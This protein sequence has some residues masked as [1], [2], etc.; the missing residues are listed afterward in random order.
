MKFRLL[1]EKTK[2]EI[3]ILGREHPNSYDYWDGNWV[4]S[5]VKVQIPGYYVDFNASLRT[6]EI[7]DFVD[8]LKLM[9]RH[10]SGKAILNNLDSF[11]HF[12]GKMDKLGHIEWSGET[13]YPV[14]TGAVLSFEF[15]S[16]QSY[17]KDLIKDLEDITDVY[18]V[19]GKP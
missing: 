18:P 16:N 2:V 9:D 13:C 15:M 3:E 14:G 4:V 11:I 17:L 19:I 7:R 12:E 5:N 6:D 10:L 8:D 1:G